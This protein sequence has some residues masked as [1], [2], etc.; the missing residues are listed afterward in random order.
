M[1]AQKPAGVNVDFCQ[2]SDYN[3]FN[4]LFL[5]RCFVSYEIDNKRPHKLT[6]NNYICGKGNYFLLTTKNMTPASN[7]QAPLM[8]FYMC[9]PK[10]LHDNEW[11]VSSSTHPTP[12]SRG[13]FWRILLK[14]MLNFWQMFLTAFILAN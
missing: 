6:N 10:G 5:I 4:R 14:L 7:K 12:S 11:L 13:F 2:N 9:Q 8:Y 1:P 3:Q